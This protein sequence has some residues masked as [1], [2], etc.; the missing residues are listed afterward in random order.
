[1]K[2]DFVTLFP[3][4]V[5]PTLDHSIIARAQSQNL[6]SF[7]AQNPRDFA[8]DNHRT[9]DDSPYGGGPGMV[10]LAPLIHQAVR[11]CSPNPQTKIILTDPAGE[12]F[13]QS[14]AEQLSQAEHL[15]FICGHYEGIDERVATQIAT[16]IL[17]IGDFVLT[18]GELPALTMTDSIV[19]LLPGVLGSPESHQD[20]SHSNSGLLGFPLYTRPVEFLGEEVPTVL[21]SGD[22]KKIAE[23]RRQQQL[24]RTKTRRPDLFARADL[25]PTDIDLL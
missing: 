16:H 2:I 18:G 17:T 11:A 20:D 23:W 15:I 19:R 13:T 1:M 3:D 21:R 22:H 24:M 8:T 5:L 9:V 6:V 25:H 14:H 4:L 10:M 7:S 12:L